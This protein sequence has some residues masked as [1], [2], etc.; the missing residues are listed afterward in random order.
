MRGGVTV[1]RK[2]WGCARWVN[3]GFG[4]QLGVMGVQGGAQSHRGVSGIYRV[5]VFEDTLLILG[6][7]LMLADWFHLKAFA[8]GS[9]AA[10][11]RRRVRRHPMGMTNGEGVTMVARAIAKCPPHYE[12]GGLP[13]EG[14][15]V[16][17]PGNGSAGRRHCRGAAQRRAERR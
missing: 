7:G 2:L 3:L 8:H 9:G 10:V 6:I 11:P 14:V 12:P 1:G 4:A 16:P 15:R 13:A 17:K 5:Y